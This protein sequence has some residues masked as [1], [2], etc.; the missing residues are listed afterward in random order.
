MTADFAERLRQPRRVPGQIT[1]GI[2]GG[3]GS[4]K[5]TIAADLAARLAPLRVEVIGLDRFFKPTDD[6]PRYASAHHGDE[7]PD[8]NRP[9]SLRLDEMITACR[10]P[11]DADV[12]ILDGHL[13]LC[14]EE[15]RA[16]LDVALFVTMDLDRMIERRTARNLARGYGGSATE[17]A[18]YCRECVVP[19]FEAHILPS[20]CWADAV[21]PN[22][23]GDDD[24][25]EA[26]LQELV[27]AVRLAT[28]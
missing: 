16:L 11:A 24:A 1:L 6:L 2:A 18:H 20:R 19:G 28:A 13:L 21:I 23:D 26:I 9:E 7:R 25:R 22:D 15:M 5:S 14:F 3:S 8:W 10:E 17:M 4:G 12:V 27:G